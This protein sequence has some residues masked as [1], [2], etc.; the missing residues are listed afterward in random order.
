MECQEYGL[1][2]QDSWEADGIAFHGDILSYGGLTG[3]DCV[4]YSPTLSPE[5]H[6]KNICK[7]RSLVFKSFI[8]CLGFDI[9]SKQLS[10][11]KPVCE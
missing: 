10:L 4:L 3:H 5:G 2:F 9:H 8:M 1:I 11:C 6:E 7:D